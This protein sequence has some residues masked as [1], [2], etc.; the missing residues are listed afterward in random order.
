MTTKKTS[1]VD[2]SLDNLAPITIGGKVKAEVEKVTLFIL[3]DVEYQIPK[4][5][6]PRVGLDYAEALTEGVDP[7]VAQLNL[8]KELLGGDAYAVLRDREKVTTE[9]FEAVMELVGR[10]AL[11][12]SESSKN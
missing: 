11:G 5:V 12:G 9:E 7:Q 6:D 8:M 3:D 10:L 4:K 1:K 2:T